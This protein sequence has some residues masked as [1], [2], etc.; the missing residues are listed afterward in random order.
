MRFI[1]Y[2]LLFQAFKIFKN[3]FVETNIFEFFNS[4]N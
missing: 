2:F 3:L 4:V 1:V